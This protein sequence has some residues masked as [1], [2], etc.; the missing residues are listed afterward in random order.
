MLPAHTDIMVA[1][2]N[3]SNSSIPQSTLPILHEIEKSFLLDDD[4]LRAI[5]DQFLK[6]FKLGLGTYGES[7]AMIPTFV[8]GTPNGTEKG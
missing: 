2:P 3:T 8:T 1:S 5:V 6:D 4:K 7:M